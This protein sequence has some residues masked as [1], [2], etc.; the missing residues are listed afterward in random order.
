[1]IRVALFDD[2]EL[3]RQ[4]LCR[5]LDLAPDFKVVAEAPSVARSIQ[6]AADTQIDVALIDVRFQDGTGMDVLAAF[7][8]MPEPPAAVML[9][10]FPDDAAMLEC[11]HL[12][13]RGFLHKDI[14]LHALLNTIRF[15]HD[16]GQLT[17]PAHHRNPRGEV[18]RDPQ[19]FQLTPRELDTL[20]LLSAGLSNKELAD[21]MAVTEGTMKNRVSNIL[22]KL[23]V[24][25][26]TGA[27]VKAIRHGLLDRDTRPEGR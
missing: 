25:D 14:G 8:T 15:V 26:R 2:Q 22:L 12:G 16:G 6:L 9:T 4:G 5:L 10:T 24:R 19:S 17:Q 7:R 11:L 20:R 27:V 21:A 1:M 13:A 3:I 18:A 23:E